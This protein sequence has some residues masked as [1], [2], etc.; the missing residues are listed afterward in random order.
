MS[1]WRG[2]LLSTGT[3]F[4]FTFTPWRHVGEC[5]YSS[6]H[7]WPRCYMEQYILNC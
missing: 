1:S 2:A 6:M 7:S 5:R 4:T 3:T